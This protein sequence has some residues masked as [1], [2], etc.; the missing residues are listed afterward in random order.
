MCGYS[1]IT[2]QS[3]ECR[4]RLLRAVPPG[5]LPARR[6]VQANP[7]SQASGEKIRPC[8]GFYSHG[9]TCEQR[10]Q[11]SRIAR[12]LAWCLPFSDKPQRHP[13]FS[14]PSRSLAACIKR[15]QRR[16]FS[17]FSSGSV[18]SVIQPSNVALRSCKAA[19]MR[20]SSKPDEST[21]RFKLSAIVSP[22]HVCFCIPSCARLHGIPLLS[23]CRK[24]RCG[25]CG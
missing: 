14:P 23:R 9:T 20:H 6:T 21:S 22:P 19:A 24:A 11:C 4:S 1:D 8:I 12:L 18:V 10:M 16:T 5:L 25:A 7:N 17:L 13:R 2:E 3:G 15:I